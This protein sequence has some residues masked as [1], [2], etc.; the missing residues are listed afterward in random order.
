M[1][2]E[3]KS[4]KDIYAESNEEKPAKKKKGWFW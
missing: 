3:G 4:W 1:I 2:N